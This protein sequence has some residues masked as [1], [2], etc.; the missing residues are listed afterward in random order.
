M[1]KTLKEWDLHFKNLSQAKRTKLIRAIKTI[2]TDPMFKKEY[3]W[4]GIFTLARI[5]RR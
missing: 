1:G 4:T 2:E 3:N 5:L